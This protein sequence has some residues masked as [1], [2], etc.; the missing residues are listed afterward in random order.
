MTIDEEEDRDLHAELFEKAWKISSS[1]IAAGNAVS[2]TPPHVRREY[3]I[4]NL[5]E[6][7]SLNII[8]GPPKSC[9]TLVAQSMAHHLSTSEQWCNHQIVR[10]C[11]VLYLG[12]EDPDSLK[13]RQAALAQREHGVLDEDIGYVGVIS[14]NIP[15]LTSDVAFIA[16][17]DFFS[18][19]CDNGPD[20]ATNKVLIIDTLNMAFSH[21]GN[22]NDAS[23][24]AEIAKFARRLCN[25][26]ITVFI[27]HH[28]GKDASKGLRGHTALSGA[29][30]NIFL[31][32]KKNK[33]NIEF[34]QEMCRNGPA[35]K[36]IHL[37][38]KEVNVDC[39]APNGVRVMAS[40]VAIF[41]ANE[42][43]PAHSLSSSEMKFLKAMHNKSMDDADFYLDEFH[44]PIG[45]KPALL[46]DVIKHAV[47]DKIAPKA[48]SLKNAT[49]TAVRAKDKL[50]ERGLIEEKNGFVWKRL[51]ETRID[52]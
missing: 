37:L 28:A 3:L 44:L 22:E 2:K 50:L 15:E 1:W 9:K 45:V 34:T 32:K 31:C 49:R 48:T 10:R 16:I 27:I 38:I 12:F 41:E 19:L 40:P 46:T 24:M 43:S 20:I 42:I 47:D 33:N 17:C 25:T 18:Y 29:V 36:K 4:E 51:H 13:L 6:K 11:N 5:V 14:D 26:N 52:R 21:L 8:Y 39:I 23:F 30:D 35:N 7:D